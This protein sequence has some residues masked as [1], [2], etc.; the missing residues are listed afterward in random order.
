MLL[1]RI[2]PTIIYQLILMGQETKI[3]GEGETCASLSPSLIN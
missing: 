2:E 1:S 3:Y